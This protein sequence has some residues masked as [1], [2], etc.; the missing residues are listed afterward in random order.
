MIVLSEPVIGIV[1]MR[2]GQRIFRTVVTDVY[3]R[4]CAVTREKALRALRDSSHPPVQ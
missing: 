4:Q 3:G 2:I 1:G